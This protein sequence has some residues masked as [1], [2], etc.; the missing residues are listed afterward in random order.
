MRMSVQAGRSDAGL[1][2]VRGGAAAYCAAK[3][4][5]VNLTRQ[6]ALDLAPEVRVNCIAP[7]FVA[8]PQFLAR[9][10]ADELRR[11]LSSITPLGRMAHPEE[12][13]RA[14]AFAVECDFMTGSVVSI[15]GGLTAGY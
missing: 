14:V 11:Q 3:A 4:G 15:D 2:G 1:V 10:D 5:V 12:V 9:D 6:L 8:T 7:G 13:A